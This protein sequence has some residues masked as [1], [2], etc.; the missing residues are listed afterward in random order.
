MQVIRD[1][2]ALSAFEASKVPTTC[3]HC[4]RELNAEFYCSRCNQVEDIGD[5]VTL[6]V[7]RISDN[8]VLVP[9][10]V[11]TATL[12]NGSFE[13]VYDECDDVNTDTEA[14]YSF[15]DVYVIAA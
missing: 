5:P 8:V 3:S 9:M 14:R 1:I 12:I 7:V 2:E 13:V 15:S 11:L 4:E 10:A 6:A